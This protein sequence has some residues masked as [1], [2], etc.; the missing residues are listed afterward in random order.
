[1]EVL[2]VACISSGKYVCFLQLRKKYETQKLERQN[3][4]RADLP[5]GVCLCHDYQIINSSL[6]QLFRL[7]PDKC[8]NQNKSLHLK[9]QIHLTTTIVQVTSKSTMMLHLFRGC[10]KAGDSSLAENDEPAEKV[11]KPCNLVLEERYTRS[12]RNCTSAS[13]HV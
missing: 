2:H 9:H 5:R 11:C 12:T 7:T 10:K 3:M 6:K 8:K 1:M 4:K 13:V